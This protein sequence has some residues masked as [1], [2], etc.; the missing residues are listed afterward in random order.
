MC[1]EGDV[2]T[3]TN[4]QSFHI[5]VGHLKMCTVLHVLFGAVGACIIFGREQF[6][7][8]CTNHMQQTGAYTIG[9]E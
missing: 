5:C 8:V 2:E 6:L 4:S 3:G 1:I 7:I 9:F